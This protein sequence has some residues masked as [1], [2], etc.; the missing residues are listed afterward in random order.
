MITQ[1]ADA[2]DASPAPLGARMLLSHEWI[3]SIGGSEN[4]FRA[5]MDVFPAADATC[6]WNDAPETFDRPVSESWLASTPLR[7]KKVLSLPLMPR[8]WEQV[9]LEGYDAVL[10]SSHAFSHHLASRAA[11]AGLNAYAYVHSPARYIWAP[12]VEARG[13][14]L[15]A[16][17]G[18]IPLKRID[19]RAADPRVHYAA[20]SEYISDRIRRAWRVDATVIYPPVDVER[21]MSVDRWRDELTAAE[22]AIF[23]ALPSDGFILGAS[24][25]VS[26][27]RLDLV[28]EVGQALGMPVVIAGSGPAE[29]RLRA[30]ADE[31]SV[32]VHFVGRVSDAQ[33][34]A[35]YQEALLFVFLALEDFG[36]MPVEAMATGTPVLVNTEGG[37]S[38]SVLGVGGGVAWAA[39]RPIAQLARAAESALAMDITDATSRVA[40]FSHAAFARRVCHWVGA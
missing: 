38:E 33:L 30:E 23:D 19:R 29:K 36:I 39:S 35:L 37:A 6:L 34:Y 4:V 26:Y 3:S 14:R 40:R 13:R 20:N 28:I 32:P 15:L 5:L 16:R 2:R 12:D 10:A 31:V 9:S 17:A 25:L 8:V 24:R 11:R 27:K 18:S 7:G 21:I 1:P 22:G